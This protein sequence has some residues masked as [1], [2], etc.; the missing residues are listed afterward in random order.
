MYASLVQS[1]FSR[2]GGALQGRWLWFADSDSAARPL[3]AALTTGGRPARGSAPADGSNDGSVA[4]GIAAALIAIV[5]AV[6]YMRAR[7]RP[8]G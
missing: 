6:V 2:R 1:A 8:F 4:V 7:R 5:L 3:S